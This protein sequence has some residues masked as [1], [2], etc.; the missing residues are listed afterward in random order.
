M[1]SLV[2]SGLSRDGGSPY[3]VHSETVL[4]SYGIIRQIPQHFVTGT[5]HGAFRRVVVDDSN[6]RV[7]FF[8]LGKRLADHPFEIPDRMVKYVEWWALYRAFSTPGEGE[9]PAMAGHYRQRYEMGKEKVKSRVRAQMN[10][11]TISM[12]THRLG[13]LDSYLERFPSDYGYSRPYRS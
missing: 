4:G 13:H 7:E 5:E 9:D 2:L 11:R 3:N 10:E 1:E 8:R 6:T 12:G